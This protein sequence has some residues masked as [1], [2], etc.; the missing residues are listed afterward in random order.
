MYMAK[1]PLRPTSGMPG[2]STMVVMATY[3]LERGSGGGG[4]DGRRG[5]T[6]AVVAAAT[7]GRDLARRRRWTT[8]TADDAVG[9][10][11]H[12]SDA[13]LKHHGKDSV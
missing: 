12:G 2:S 4:E 9:L 13:T 8:T 7:S 6:A 3:S 10:L 5:P 1:P 11:G